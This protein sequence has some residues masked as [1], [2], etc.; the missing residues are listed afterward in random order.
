MHRRR[1][2]SCCGCGICE[3]QAA[4]PSGRRVCPAFS[5]QKLPFTSSCVRSRLER[6]SWP[7]QTQAAPSISK[8]APCTLPEPDTEAE[9]AGSKFPAVVIAA[10]AAVA[11]VC[12]QQKCQRQA[13][14]QPA[15]GAAKMQSPRACDFEWA[16]FKEGM[17]THCSA[18]G[19]S[20]PLQPQSCSKVAHSGQEFEAYVHTSIS[21]SRMQ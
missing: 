20:P 7:V 19:I 10:A 18:S 15:C 4:R 5:T 14:H 6:A 21:Y 11:G 13:A 1:P 3:S 9:A 2:A 12:R 16:R 17:P 8:V